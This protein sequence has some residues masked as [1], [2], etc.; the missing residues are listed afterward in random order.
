MIGNTWRRRQSYQS[1]SKDAI[2]RYRT[3][4]N[5]QNILEV[6]ALAII[7]LVEIY[8][9]FSSMNS[10]GGC[11]TFAYLYNGYNVPG[12][13]CNNWHISSHIEAPSNQPYYPQSSVFS[14]ASSV[15]SSPHLYPICALHYGEGA[16]NTS[17]RMV[18]PS[19]ERLVSASLTKAK[20]TVLCS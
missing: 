12:A 8:Q 14:T 6:F 4:Q 11:Y 20:F 13:S 7:A 18:I 5:A 10:P 17:Y 2:L 19:K 9:D 16:S 3:S 1:K 15:W